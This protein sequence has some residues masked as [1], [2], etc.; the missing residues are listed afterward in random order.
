MNLGRFTRLAVAGLLLGLAVPA[1]AQDYPNRPVTM[2]VPYAAGGGL[3]VFARQIAQKLSERLGKTFVVENRPGSGTVIGASYVAKAA[4]D[5]YT[6]M[7][8]TSSAFAINA[9]LRKS[10]PYDPVKDFAPIIHTSDAPFLLLVHPSLPIKSVSDW[11]KY[12]KAQPKPPSY[13]SAGPGSPQHLS[14]EL[15]KSLTGT[16]LVHIPYKG[17]A[18]ALNDLIAGH[19]PTQFAQPTPVLPLLAGGKV[20]ALAVSS[21]KRLP[22]LPKIPPLAE[23]GVPEFDFVSWQMIVAP[24]ATPKP[25][26]EKLYR[27]LKAILDTPE[28][29]KEFAKT[30]RIE[31]DSPPPDKL[32]QFMRDEI[33]RMGK[34]V[35]AAGLARSQ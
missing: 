12:M 19:V 23:S 18:P 24:A 11:V 16:K 30:G 20:R 17:D 35:K 22:P 13:G 10:L 9:T 5:G 26:V 14:M 15:L 6:I 29:K 4:P 34:I 33:V 27:E 7:L 3:D 32:K 21:T 8:A 2:V 28:M 1:A 25:I 31:V